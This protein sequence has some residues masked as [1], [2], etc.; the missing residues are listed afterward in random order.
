[1]LKI[2]PQDR[3]TPTPT[4]SSEAMDDFANEDTFGTA[5]KKKKEMDDFANE[6]TFG[7]AAKKKKVNSGNAVATLVEKRC[8]KCDV[9]KPVERFG[10]N[11]RRTYC[12]SCENIQKRKAE[13]KN[14]N[15]KLTKKQLE[16]LHKECSK[17]GEDKLLKEYNNGGYRAQCKAC[18]KIYDS[19]K[20][21][22]RIPTPDFKAC[23]M[24]HTEKS[25]DNYSLSRSNKDGHDNRCK[26]CVNLYAQN[27]KDTVVPNRPDEKECTYCKL[28]KPASEFTEVKT[29]IGLRSRC[30]GCRNAEVNAHSLE[31]KKSECCAHCGNQDHRTFE[32]DHV[33]PQTKAVFLSGK[34]KGMS[35]MTSIDTFTSELEFT[36][37]LCCF[38]HHLKTK[39]DGDKKKKEIVSSA[40]KNARKKRKERCEVTDQEKLHREECALCH[41]TVTP[42]EVRGFF[43]IS[44]KSGTMTISDM[45]CTHYKPILEICE[46]MEK[47]V[48]LC[49]NCTKIK[50]STEKTDEET[51]AISKLFEQ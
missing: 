4:M 7:T 20:V 49:A 37:T 27:W 36:Q 45:C 11:G 18:I 5:A 2:T 47:C 17:C 48:L 22:K 42:E 31:K 21:V 1:M 35:K 24:C 33:N 13:K 26:A 6:D 10:R 39:V 43:F 28:L 15:P 19:N 44:K 30:H 14:P 29:K 34:T 51:A 12:L 16:T 23:T 32:Y 41:R 25:I 50:W 40:A 9:V 46:A 8:T 3:V 38:C